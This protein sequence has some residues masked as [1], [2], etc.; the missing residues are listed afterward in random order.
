[1]VL[2][3]CVKTKS[4]H[5]ASPS[6]ERIC[7]SPCVMGSTSLRP[8]TLQQRNDLPP[9]ASLPRPI[10][11]E[12]PALTL[13][14]FFLPGC[15]SPCWP[16]YLPPACQRGYSLMFVFLKRA[17]PPW[18]SYESLISQDQGANFTPKPVGRF[19]LNFSNRGK[20]PLSNPKEGWVH[21]ALHHSPCVQEW[22]GPAARALTRAQQGSNGSIYFIEQTKRKT[23]GVLFGTNTTIC[24]KHVNFT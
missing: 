17:W 13:G 11:G 3:W 6:R 16:P 19:L 24:L 5:H 23:R 9:A 8:L 20:N 2:T 21:P 7:C 22:H 15:E 18:L 4:N 14:Q 10:P 1:M 12:R